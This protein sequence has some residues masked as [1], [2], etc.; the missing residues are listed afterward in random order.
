VESSGN[1]DRRR[2]A[3]AAPIL[4]QARDLGFLQVR[5]LLHAVREQHEVAQRHPL[6]IQHASAAAHGAADRDVADGRNVV[7]EKTWI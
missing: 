6:A 2:R 5:A 1:A 7:S 3:A 4:G